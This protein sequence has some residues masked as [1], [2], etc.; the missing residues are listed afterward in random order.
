[1]ATKNN[2]GANC[3]HAR[4]PFATCGNKNALVDPIP[5]PVTDAECG[6]S[7]SPPYFYRPS[8]ANTVCNSIPC[9]VSVIGAG[10]H[11]KCCSIDVTRPTITAYN[12]AQAA[13]SVSTG[14]AVQLTFSEAVQAG[15]GTIKLTPNAGNVGAFSVPNPNP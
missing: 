15:Q 4:I 10:D 14:T 7:N 11:A 6:S 12:P 13:T 9:D 8:T 1:M 5:N 3:L 2:D